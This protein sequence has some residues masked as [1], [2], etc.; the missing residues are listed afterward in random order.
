MTTPKVRTWYQ[1]QFNAPSSRLTLIERLLKNFGF[2]GSITLTIGVMAVLII[3]ALG[4]W[5]ALHNTGWM[6]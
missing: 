4:F 5:Q 6:S 3:W 2:W 1:S